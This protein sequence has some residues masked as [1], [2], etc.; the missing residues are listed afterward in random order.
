MKMYELRD[1]AYENALPTASNTRTRNRGPTKT[2]PPTDR[3]RA[4]PRRRGQAGRVL[5][6]DMVL[7]K[8]SSRRRNKT[9]QQDRGQHALHP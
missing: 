4:D 6:I 8:L 7:D 2:A 5:G 1:S 3:R 9:Q